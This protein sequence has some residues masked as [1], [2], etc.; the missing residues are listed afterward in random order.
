MPELPTNLEIERA[1]NLL[2]GFGWNIKKEEVTE[3]QITLTI[4]KKREV[5]IK[6]TPT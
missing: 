6:P 1:R 4:S 2:R 5:E 3:T